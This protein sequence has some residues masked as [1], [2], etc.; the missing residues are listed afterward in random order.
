ML[1][2][3]LWR[4]TRT[5]DADDST[6]NDRLLTWHK[7]TRTSTVL[8]QNGLDINYKIDTLMHCASAFGINY[9]MLIS[10]HYKKLRYRGVVN[11]GGSLRNVIVFLTMKCE[12]IVIDSFL[13]YVFWGR[14][15]FVIVLY[16]TNSD[17][18]PR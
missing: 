2:K 7:H 10:S 5:A 17:F 4:R 6:E 18:K 15:E 13:A 3:W 11:G 12:F 8:S 14:C 16:I 9:L 1:L